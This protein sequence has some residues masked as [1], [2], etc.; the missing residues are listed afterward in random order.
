MASVHRQFHPTTPHSRSR[1]DFIIFTWKALRGLETWASASSHSKTL[2][3]SVKFTSPGIPPIKKKR[4]KVHST[5]LAFLPCS[6]IPLDQLPEFLFQSEKSSQVFSAA[7]HIL[8]QWPETTSTLL[9]TN[10]CLLCYLSAGVCLP[11]TRSINKMNGKNIS[12]PNQFRLYASSANTFAQ[13][14]KAFGFV[15]PRLLVFFLKEWNRAH[16]R[17]KRQVHRYTNPGSQGSM[18]KEASMVK[19]H[20]LCG[21]V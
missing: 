12:K 2:L 16:L 18:R 3:Q 7:G 15:H 5:L 11:E 20:A 1:L 6:K 10:K 13:I 9:I 21:S 4:K 19:H 14:C 8:L 17:R